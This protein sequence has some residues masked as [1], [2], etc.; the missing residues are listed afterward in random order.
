MTGESSRLQGFAPIAAP[1]ARVLVLG[2]MPSVRSL[3]EHRYYAHPRNRFWPVMGQLLTGTPEGIPYEQAA[4]VFARSGIALWDT[5]A[6]CRRAGSLDSAI[7]GE[8][9]NDIPGFVRRH[10]RLRAVIFNGRKSAETFRRAFGE[11]FLEEHSIRAMCLPSTSPANAA[12]S[13]ERL[14]EAWGD[15]LSSCGIALHAGPVTG[16]G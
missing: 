13:F 1:D 5:I 16:P 8:L 11:G 12:W 4:D 2:S 14:C 6:S 10:A 15:A 3:E 9:P 7:R